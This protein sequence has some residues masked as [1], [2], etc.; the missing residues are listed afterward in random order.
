[1]AEDIVFSGSSGVL[2]PW[3]SMVLVLLLMAVAVAAFT[4]RRHRL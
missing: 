3:W 2:L 1:M 4:V